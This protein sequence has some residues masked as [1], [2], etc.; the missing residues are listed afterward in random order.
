MAALQAEPSLDVLIADRVDF[1]RDKACG[2][3]IAPHAVDVLDELGCADEVVGG[4][5]SIPRLRLQLRSRGVDRTM[6]RPTYVIPRQ[7][8]DHRLVTAAKHAGARLQRRKVTDVRRGRDHLDLGDGLT[9]RVV[10][11]ADGVHSVLRRQS[12]FSEPR[13]AMAL[14][15][16]VPTPVELRGAQTIVFGHERQP[17]YAWCFDRGDGWANV[18]YG[19]LLPG[20]HTTPSKQ[21]MIAL[22]EELIPG[23]TAEATDWRGAKL[24]L[25]DGD[26][27]P[28]RGRLLLAGDAAG[29]VNPMTGEGIFYAVLTGMAAGRAASDAIAAGDPFSAAT[30]YRRQVEPLLGRHLK[31][32]DIAARLCRSDTVLAA[33]LGAAAGSQRVFDDL[34]ELGLA[35]GSITPHAL[36]ALARR[37]PQA[38]A[39]SRR[40]RP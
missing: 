26:W 12:R 33:G 22:L 7:E 32:V 40:H 15:G 31:H 24:P 20:A 2:D 13:M 39:R 38:I 8:L 6:P 19:E 35:H 4:H 9:G 23:T 1:P 11:G 25:S 18:G 16:Y 34:V 10:I 30:R 3:G 17:A 21:Q 14:R 27:R 28:G 37:L 29:L 36:S 5:A